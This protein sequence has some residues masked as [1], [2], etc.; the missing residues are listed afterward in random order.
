MLV[1]GGGI[2]CRKKAV[3]L[4]PGGIDSM[5]HYLFVDLRRWRSISSERKTQTPHE[6][7]VEQPSSIRSKAA[8]NDQVEQE[9]KRGRATSDQ[10]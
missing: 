10:Q 1:I 2:A 5:E 4:T 7:A 9:S 3:L 8:R 6:A